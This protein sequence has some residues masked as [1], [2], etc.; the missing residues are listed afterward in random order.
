MKAKE[1][2]KNIIGP[3]DCLWA[4]LDHL[5][6]VNEGVIDLNMLLGLVEQR[7]ILAGQ[8]QSRGSYFRRQRVLTVL[9]KNKRKVK[10]FLKEGAH[11]FE[12]EQESPFLGKVSKEG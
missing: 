7:V 2:L 1:N 8:C 6:K 4:H 12:K 10:S 11:C 5:K 3:L 9:F